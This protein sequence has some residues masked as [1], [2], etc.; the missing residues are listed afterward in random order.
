MPW[1][2]FQF[3]LKFARDSLFYLWV[4]I[5]HLTIIRVFAKLKKD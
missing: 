2:E 4:E 1:R 3:L 5:T